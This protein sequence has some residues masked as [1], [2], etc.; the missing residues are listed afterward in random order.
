MEVGLIGL[1]GQI[2]LLN[3]AEEFKKDIENAGNWLYF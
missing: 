1:H 3:V 2:A